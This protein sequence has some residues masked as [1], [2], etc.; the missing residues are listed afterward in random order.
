MGGDD[1]TMI[2]NGEESEAVAMA[3]T[4]LDGFR[5]PFAVEGV[6]YHLSA[7]IGI[8]MHPSHATDSQSLGRY[9]ELAMYHAKSL[10]RD[11]YAMYNAQLE[12]TVDSKTTLERYLRR[13]IIEDQ[14]VMHYQPLA[15]LR[16]GRVCCLE[17]LIRWNDPARGLIPPAEF[18]PPAEESGLIVAIGNVVLERACAQMA[19]WQERA[20]PGL[21]LAINLSIR[22]F[23]QRDLCE[24]LE[25]ILARTGLPA[26][27]LE[28]ELTESTAMSDPVRAVETMRAIRKLGIRL[29]VDD[30]GTGYSSLSYLKRLPIDAVKIDKTFIDDI[31]HDRD[32]A[33]I[34]TSIIAMAHNLGLEVTAEGVEN[35][36]Q[37]TFLSEHG[38]DMVQGYHLSRPLPAAEIERFLGDAMMESSQ[39]PH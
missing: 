33:T 18:I 30:F 22:Q 6:E 27:A 8:A 31:L 4:V 24:Q 20:G 21:R 26:S 16:D 12:V 10:G 9:A 17:A 13:A 39:R 29:V 14:F 23:Y 2:V 7:S 34:V 28:L 11:T 35:A 36:E 1:F 37:L 38:C 32:D 5:T 25:A 15:V 19:A 3:E